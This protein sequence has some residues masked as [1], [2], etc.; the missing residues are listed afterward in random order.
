M[1]TNPLSFLVK[2]PMRYIL[3]ALAAAGALALAARPGTNPYLGKSLQ[4]I[5]PKDREAITVEDLR[6]LNRQQLVGIFHQLV[7][8][9]V[10][11]MRGEYR[12]ML[13]DSGNAVNRFLS[14]LFLYLTWGMWMHKAFEPVSE[15]HGH[16][17]NTF[18]ATLPRVP[19]NVFAAGAA[20]LFGIV[21]AAFGS[22]SPQR[23]V[24]MMCNRTFIGPSRFDRRTSFH[25]VYSD[26]NSFYTSTMRDEVRKVNDTLFLGLG[27]LTITGGTRNIF[28]FVLMGPPDPWVGPDEGYPE[29]R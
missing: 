27:T 8:P 19:E 3:T 22:S 6:K 10:G 18:L 15:R 11:E 25:L 13:M 23:M 26:Y 2:I 12:A 17:Y 7:S 5:I 29:D 24:R 21:K 16:G 20:S 4:S 1:M 28:P 14:V 9:E